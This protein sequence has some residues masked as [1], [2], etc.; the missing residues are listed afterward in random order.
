MFAALTV[1][2]WP[3]TFQKDDKPVASY[4]FP[5]YVIGSTLLFIGMF[6]CAFIM[7]RSSKEYYLQPQKPSKIYWLQ[8][9]KQNADDQV[10]KAFLTTKEYGG[11]SVAENLSYI[12]SVRD[13][14]FH[15]KYLQIYSTLAST[16]LGFIFQFVGLRGLHASVI[17]AQ[18][19]STFLM[20]IVR[21]IL[22]TERMAPEE[23]E[24]RDEQK[25]LSS[26]QQELDCFAF[27]LENIDSFH[28][29]LPPDRPTTLSSPGYIFHP[30]LSLAK[31]LIHTR[32]RLAELTSSSNQG[33][34]V[35]WDDMPIRQVAQNLAR[36][37]EMTMDLM[38][39]SWEID[40]GKT[41]IFNLLAECRTSSQSSEP[42]I[43]SY[44]MILL[45]GSDTLRWR[46]DVNELEAILGLWVWSIE[47][48]NDNT[49]DFKI[50]RLVG[51]G[52]DDAQR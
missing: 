47:K 11:P 44:C 21:T 19:G 46:I 23:N 32:S 10:F 41:F 12:K 20:A 6:F 3:E 9:G 14:R 16:L 27:H 7:E 48:A 18:L 15:R 8:P 4:A 28:L 34:T 29:R 13:Y 37:I 25:L 30:S 45:R 50:H 31:H 5:F 51:L 39:T 2:M 42:V 26:T 35:A 1:F 17:L 52:K 38:A 24:F 49:P 43:E 33:L 36:A 40:L 22:R